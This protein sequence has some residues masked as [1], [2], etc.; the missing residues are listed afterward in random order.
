MERDLIN[1]KSTALIV[2]D[3]QN[4]YCSPT[5][6]VSKRGFAVDHFSKLVD[7][8]IKFTDKA[9]SIGVPIIF[10]RM[11]ED[12]KYMAKNAKLLIKD[13]LCSPNTTGF[14]Y[15]KIKP[16]KGDLQIIKKSFDAFSNPRLEQFLKKKRIKNLIL[17]GVY[18]AV[19]VDTTIRS[20]F[21]RGY[22]IIVP[23]DLISTRRKE[24]IAAI[25][26]WRE[27]FAHLTNSNEILT[28]WG[29]L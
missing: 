20:G 12:P 19:C 2:I 1:P 24:E 4:D 27:N 7:N 3:I 9:R 17:I 15:Y 29:I 6:K 8:I 16:K 11:I 26:V 10:T 13:A 14:N 25:N 21:T 22:N 28:I 5:G 18:S 23:R